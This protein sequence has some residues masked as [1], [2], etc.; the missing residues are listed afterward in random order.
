MRGHHW[1]FKIF[2]QKTLE[3][4][5]KTMKKLCKYLKYFVC[6]NS[7]VLETLFESPCMYNF[8]LVIVKKSKVLHFVI[9]DLGINSVQ[10]FF[11]KKNKIFS[12]PVRH[13]Y[14]DV[15][16]TFIFIP[17]VMKLTMH[18]LTHIFFDIYQIIFSWIS[19]FSLEEV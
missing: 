13:R 12:R 17:M 18:F 16:Y 9:W 15:I 10:Y 6:N 8:K 2:I 4:S 3:C 5:K 7:L 19:I 1:H 14:L 11:L